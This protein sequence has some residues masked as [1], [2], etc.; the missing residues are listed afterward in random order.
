MTPTVEHC[1]ACGVILSD[2]KGQRSHRS[3]GHFFAR[4]NEA[5]ETM[6]DRYK[7]R[8]PSADHLRKWALIKSGF[9]D[10]ELYAFDT[11][12]DAVMA[13]AALKKADSYALVRVEGD[14][15]R[16]FTA[17]SQAMPAMSKEDFQK[18]KDMVFDVISQLLGADVSQAAA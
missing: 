5:W 12:E 16:F 3:H 10:I 1:P 18:S 11:P 7:E 13:S 8:F 15:V 4:V 9:C 17:H 2:K 14:E 6:P